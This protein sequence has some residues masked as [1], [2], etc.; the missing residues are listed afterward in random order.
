VTVTDPDSDPVIVTEHVRSERVHVV[1]TKETEPAP[2]WDQATVPVGPYPVTLAVQVMT[3]DE[4]VTAD[5]GVQETAVLGSFA[6]TV[7]LYA[8][9]DREFWGDPS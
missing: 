9:A 7:R 3:A 5:F 1:E 4:P 6:D 2:L 8:P